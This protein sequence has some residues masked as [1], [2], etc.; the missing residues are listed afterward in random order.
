MNVI[1]FIIPEIFLSFSIFV[2]LMIGV[3]L[4]NSFEII[5]RLSILVIISI[6]LIIFTG[7]I[8]YAKIFN[9][10][11]VIDSFSSYSKILILIS[12]FFILLITKKKYC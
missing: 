7:N 9:E 12:S 1:Q 2:L 5:Y 8:D 11:F 10:S 4:K 3:F 6:L